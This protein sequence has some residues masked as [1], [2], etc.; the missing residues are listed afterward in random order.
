MNVPTVG[1][2]VLGSVGAAGTLGKEIRI[3]WTEG[4]TLHV[5]L[6]SHETAKCGHALFGGNVKLEREV[7]GGGG[8][9][10]Q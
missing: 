2:W 6:G 1:M 5:G 3:R 8:G 4:E 7:C 10:M 9:E